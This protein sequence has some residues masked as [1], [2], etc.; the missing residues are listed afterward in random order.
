[1]KCKAGDKV[2]IKTRATMMSEFRCNLSGDIQVGPDCCFSKKM[3]E[4]MPSDRIIMLTM[5]NEDDE[6]INGP[7][8]WRPK[9]NETRPFRIVDGMIESLVESG[10]KRPVNEDVIGI[11]KPGTVVPAERKSIQIINGEDCDITALC[12]D[13]TIWTHTKDRYD[14]DTIIWSWVQIKTPFPGINS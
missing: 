11:S 6:F 3:E 2:K 9:G 5:P 14:G 12:N 1:M 7:L 10:P 8:C 13:G 4:A